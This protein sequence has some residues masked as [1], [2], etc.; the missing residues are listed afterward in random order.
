MQ[1]DQDVIPEFFYRESIFV[2][3]GNLEF[4]F[5]D[6]FQEELPQA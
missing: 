5:F 1:N 4:S 6:L 2:K 3:Q